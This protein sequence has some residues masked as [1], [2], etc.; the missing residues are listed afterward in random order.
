MELVT[1]TE[2]FPIVAHQGG[3][4]EF[5]LV[6]SPL[7]VIGGLL[8]LANRRVSAQVESAEEKSD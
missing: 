5:L 8:W 6:A 7:A 3:W 2:L 1:I 4:D